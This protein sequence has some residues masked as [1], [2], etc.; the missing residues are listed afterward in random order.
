MPLS[1]FEVITTGTF[2]WLG[3]G[4]AG[5][6][7]GLEKALICSVHLKLAAAAVVEEM[8]KEY[9]T[10]KEKGEHEIRVKDVYQYWAVRIFM[11]GK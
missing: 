11:H 9:Y 10:M 5:G 7:Q 2:K 1:S 6:V 3:I 4:E 8:V